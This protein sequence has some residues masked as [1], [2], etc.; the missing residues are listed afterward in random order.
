MNVLIVEVSMSVIMTILI[1]LF[2]VKIVWENSVTI[3]IMIIAHS[4][5]RIIRFAGIIKTVFVLVDK[6]QF[7]ILFGS[8]SILATCQV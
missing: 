2:I 5:M 7:L 4:G 8:S 1:I 3:V 6:I